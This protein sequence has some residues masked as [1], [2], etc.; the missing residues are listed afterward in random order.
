[1]RLTWNGSTLTDATVLLTLPVGTG[2]NGGALVVGPDGKLY[3]SIGEAGS[4]NGQLQN[5]PEGTPPND[6]SIIFRLELDGSTPPDNPFFGLGGAMQKV[7]AY[8]L[9]NVF[10]LDFDPVTNVLWNTDNGA[11]DYDEV[12]RVPPGMNGGWRQIMGPDARDPEG[13]NDLWMAAGATYVDP[14][15]SFFDSFGITAIHF[16]RGPGLGAHYDGDLFVAAPQQHGCLPFRAEC[17]AQRRARPRSCRGRP[18]GGHRCR[19]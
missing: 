19:A 18:G 8:G 3:G 10:G 2:H 12:N 14:E 1:M 7:Y 16:Q 17:G 11:A 6:T 15:F 5:V 9:R 13:V 4:L